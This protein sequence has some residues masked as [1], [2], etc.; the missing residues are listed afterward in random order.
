MYEEWGGRDYILHIKQNDWWKAKWKTLFG[1]EEGETEPLYP[2]SK[3][4][5]GNSRPKPD[6]IK[7]ALMV[8]ELKDQYLRDGNENEVDGFKGDK[9]EIAKY[10]AKWEYPKRRDRGK[11]DPSFDPED[12]VFNIARKSIANTMVKEDLEEF[13]KQKRTLQSRVG[14]YMSKADDHLENVCR[15]QFP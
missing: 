8:Y 7:F 12:W 13:R 5:K 4:P 15:G 3:G 10:I 6:A 11:I 9:W 1:Y 14:R 2:L